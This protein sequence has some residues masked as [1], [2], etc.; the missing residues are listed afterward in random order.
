M[1]CQVND[2]EYLKVTNNGG[3]VS[4]LSV[5]LII[6]GLFIMI[7]GGVGTAGAILAN[8]LYGRITLIVVSDKML[9]YECAVNS[10]IVWQ[11]ELEPLILLLKIGDANI[12]W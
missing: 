12:M 9:C 1:S 8:N 5:L 6:V 3:G 4:E 11:M 2:S 7:L 10:Y